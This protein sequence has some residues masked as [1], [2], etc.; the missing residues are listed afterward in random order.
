M[1]KNVVKEYQ[2]LRNQ[3]D[4]CTL[5]ALTEKHPAMKMFWKNAVWSF[6]N[7]LEHLMDSVIL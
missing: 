5:K 7:R 2:Y 3:I 1:E 4:R 6:E